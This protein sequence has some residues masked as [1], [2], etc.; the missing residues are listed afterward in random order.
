MHMISSS[1]NQKFSLHA[2]PYFFSYILLKYV[3][4]QNFNP[5]NFHLWLSYRNFCFANNPLY[6]R[7]YSYMVRMCIPTFFIVNALYGDKVG[8]GGFHYQSYI[9]L[10]SP[11]QSGLLNSIAFFCVEYTN[12][13]AKC[14]QSKSRM[15]ITTLLGRAVWNLII[16]PVVNMMALGIVINLIVSEG[17]HGGDSDYDPNNNLKD[18]IK[19]FLSLL[20]EAYYTC[21]LLYLGICMVGKLKDF[22]GILVLKSLLL[23]SAK[24]LVLILICDVY[25]YVIL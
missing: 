14:M 2:N 13:K 8:P 6:G 15:S 20:G 21:A 18:W 3:N 1:C 25:V 7:S 19:K 16:N 24:L 17:I 5:L 9:Y 11:L 22:N 10:I 12:E 4:S 23:C